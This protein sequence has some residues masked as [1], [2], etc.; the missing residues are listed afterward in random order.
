[1]MPDRTIGTTG[2]VVTPI[3]FG[4][5]AL[6]SMPDTYGYEVDEERARATVRAIFDGPANVIDSSRNYGFGRSERLVGDVIRELGGVPEGFV[7]STKLDRDSE[8]GRFDADM[9]RHSLEESLRALSL[10]RV[11]V[12][13]L[14]RDVSQQSNVDIDNNLVVFNIR[15]LEDELRPVAMYIVLNYIWN[16]TKADQR[17]RLLIDG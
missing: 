13:R 14:R 11:D 7:V 15:D 16:K 2:V 3:A 4:T 12:L 8:T 17:K 6:G 1:M 9:A 10:E 5:S